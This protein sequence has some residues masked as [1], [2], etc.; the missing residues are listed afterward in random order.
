MDYLYVF[1]YSQ[2]IPKKMPCVRK[3]RALQCFIQLSE[4]LRLPLSPS[5]PIG[6][7]QAIRSDQWPIPK[8]EQVLATSARRLQWVASH[9]LVAALGS[10][11]V[12]VTFGLTAGLAYGASGAGVGHELPQVL[13]A[14]LVYLPALWVLIGLR[15]VTC[16]PL[17]TCPGS[18][19][20][21]RLRHR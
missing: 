16:H 20:A 11:V 9:L 5:T 7:E 14:A 19:S 1:V 2:H 6:L 3:R 8:D 18:C 17:P 13:A 4:S 10:A 21:T 15:C 12:L